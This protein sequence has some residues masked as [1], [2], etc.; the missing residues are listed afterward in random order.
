[1]TVSS[2]SP[3]GQVKAKHDASNVLAGPLAKKMIL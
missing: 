1:M 2:E 3:L